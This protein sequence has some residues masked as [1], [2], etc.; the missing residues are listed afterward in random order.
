MTAHRNGT[1]WLRLTALL[2]VLLPVVFLAGC[3]L[4]QYPQSSLNPQADYARQI[5]SILEL[6]TIWVVIIFA[7]VQGLLI[8]AVVKFRNRPGAPEPKPVHGNTMLE[9]AWTIAPAIILTM[10]AIPT[11]LTIFKTQENPPANALNVTV[12]GHQ[13][14]WEF[15]YPSQNIMTASEMVVPVGK[16]VYMTIKT[17]DV[18]HSFWFPAMGGKRDAVGNRENHMWFTPDS[19][20]EFP[21]QCAELCGTSH[22]NMRMKIRVVTPAEYDAW[23]A[24]QQA[25]PVAPEEG[26][27]EAQGLAIYRSSACIACHT[28]QGISPGAIGPNLTH[29]GSRET[30]AGGMFVNTPDEMEAWIKNAPGRKPGAKML[31]LDAMKLK[32]EQVKPIVAYLQSLK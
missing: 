11:V 8:V 24:A 13:W 3:T 25:P 31:S 28:I 15:R 7:L 17:A 29:I 6:Q 23:V 26:S 20:G 30:L 5:Q 27:I 12:V 19:T 22:A 10:V 18:L 1:R 16:P 21:G 2:L 9:I 4:Q 14:W 32:P